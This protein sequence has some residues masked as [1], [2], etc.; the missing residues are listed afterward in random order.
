MSES[1]TLEGTQLG[2]YRIERLLG[3]GAMG[4]VYLAV[5]EA[6]GR[7]VAIKKLKPAI[8]A[9]PAMNERFFAEARAVNII[10]HENIVECTDLV[11]NGANSYIVMELLEGRTLSTAIRDARKMPA[12]RA[13]KIAAQIA[14]ALAAAHGKGIVHR[15]LK[16]DNVFLI[17]RA[18]SSDYVKVLDFGMARLRPE[19]GGVGATQS[20][21][22]IGTPAY[23]SP[24]QAR[25]EKVGPPADIYALGVVL[26]HMLTGQ[27]PF[28]AESLTMMLI[29]IVQEAPPKVHALAKDLPA[30]LVDLVDRCLAKDPAQRPADMATLRRELLESVGLPVETAQSIAGTQS[31]LAAGTSPTFG[32]DAT[33]DS[34]PVAR[35]SQTALGELGLGE[36]VAPPAWAGQS[37]VSAAAGQVEKPVGKRPPWALIGAGVGAIAIA[38]TIG[39]VATRDGGHKDVQPSAAPASPATSNPATAPAPTTETQPASP[40]PVVETSPPAASQPPVVEAT[41]AP[42][43]AAVEAPTPTT[44]APKP[45][46][47]PKPKP[48]PAT[49]K[50]GTGSAGSAAAPPPPPPVDKPPEKVDRTKVLVGPKP[51]S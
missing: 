18:G 4:E 32:L 8:A 5:H 26:F 16:P 29:A 24:E 2:S 13:V 31:P 10:R 40:A 9:N 46:P 51:G 14:D 17:K 36:T 49:A 39:I 30:P 44:P 25:G 37:S 43:T 23:M 38:A 3:E 12:T 27:L 21:A 7:Q 42:A 22:L 48:K 11:N 15:D 1:A 6:L 35:V 45:A 33:L 50:L 19:L 28:S 20:G 47:K 34:G 41:P